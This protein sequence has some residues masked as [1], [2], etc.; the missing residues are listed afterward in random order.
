[1]IYIRYPHIVGKTD[2]EKVDEL[3]RYLH[4]LVDQLNYVLET[5]NTGQNRMTDAEKKEVAEIVKNSIPFY[6]GKVI[7]L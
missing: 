3:Q 5:S 6:D 2:K 1:M 4:Y 7:Q